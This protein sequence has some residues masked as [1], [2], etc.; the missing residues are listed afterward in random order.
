MPACQA[1]CHGFKSHPPLHP[2]PVHVNSEKQ[3]S[4]G[5]PYY[6]W[7]VYVI[8]SSNTK[9]KYIGTTDNLKRRLSEHNNGICKASAPY[10]PFNLEAYIA[11]KNKSKALEI[12]QYFKTGSGHSFLER[13]IL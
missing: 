1:G 11:V 10:K 13:R 9:Y 12:E 3:A 8:K 5:K 7:Y 4:D 2:T 6:M